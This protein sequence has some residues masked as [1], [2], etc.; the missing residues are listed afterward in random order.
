[1]SVLHGSVNGGPR[2]PHV[3]TRGGFCRGWLFFLSNFF[4]IVVKRTN[5]GFTVVSTSRCGPAARCAFT[6]P[7]PGL[8][9]LPEA[10]PCAHWTPPPR[11]PP[12]C[13]SP[14]RRHF[15]EHPHCPQD[16]RRPVHWPSARSPSPSSHGRGPWATPT[17]PAMC[18]H[19][20][21]RMRAQERGRLVSNFR[22]HSGVCRRDWEPGASIQAR[23]AA[24]GRG[25]G[26]GGASGMK[27]SPRATGLRW[28]LW[29]LLVLRERANSG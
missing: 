11:A 12:L 18:A 10:K 5:I 24:Q 3:G 22:D 6:L 7:T 15:L 16:E 14:S 17:S 9:R 23:A 25:D 26:A 4:Q 2:S 29:D 21:W 19:A 13:K 1:M 8:P 27:G 28:R 20:C